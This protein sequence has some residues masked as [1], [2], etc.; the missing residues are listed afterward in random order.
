MNV[1]EVIGSVL[2][3]VGALTSLL[4]AIGVVRLPDALTRMHAATKPASLGLVLLTTGA[5]LIASDLAVTAR[6][7]LAM[8]VQL[9][10]V[11]T[12]AQLLGRAVAG[13]ADA[14]ARQAEPEPQAKPEPQ[15]QP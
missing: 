10:T 14:P 12:G 5:I 9:W 2:L 15:E 13:P 6:L 1:A 4:G 11:A 7:G 3:V 8:M